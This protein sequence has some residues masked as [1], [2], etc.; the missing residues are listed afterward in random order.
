MWEQKEGPWWESWQGWE[1]G[2]SRSEALRASRK[3]GNRQLQ[4]LGG[5]GT[6]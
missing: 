4:E 1:K 6:L 5:G 2:K 3:N